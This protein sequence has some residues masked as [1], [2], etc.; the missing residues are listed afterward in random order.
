MLVLDPDVT[1]ARKRRHDF[2]IA[3]EIG[4]A[5]P[6]A[7]TSPIISKTEQVESGASLLISKPFKS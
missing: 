3:A 7:I 1:D 4:Y 6:G 5:D 2:I